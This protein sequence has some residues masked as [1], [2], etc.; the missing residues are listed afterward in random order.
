MIAF[1]RDVSPSIDR[2]ELT[3]LAREPIDLDRARAQHRAYEKT[4]ARL[5]CEVRRL[6]D[7]SELPDAVFVSDTAV[8]LDEVAVIARPGAESRRP[9]TASVAAALAPLRPLRHIE[10]PGT[11]D[12]GDVIRIGRIIHVGQSGRTNAAGIEQ[13]RD[14]L[15]SFGYEV[16]GVPLSGCLHLQ[17]AATPV[18]DR[19]LVVNREFV[20]PSAFGD[21]EVI[22]VDPSE[23]FGANALWLGHAIVYPNDCPRTRDRLVARGLRV[24][25]VD[26]S[27]LAKAEAGVTCSCLLVTHSSG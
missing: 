9:E 2:C 12:G 15:R 21:V 24:V 13:L 20:D 8:V 3:H 16:R 17:S 26:V 23:P 10:L 1:T 19:V 18:A 25:T 14:W 7:A 22:D 11:L 5:G 6:P 4:L 27:E